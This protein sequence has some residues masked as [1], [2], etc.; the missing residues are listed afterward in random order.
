MSAPK[1]NYVHGEDTL[2]VAYYTYLFATLILPSLFMV[3][4]IV[5]NE[6]GWGWQ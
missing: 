5:L 2:P 6:S 1:G 4:I 3:A